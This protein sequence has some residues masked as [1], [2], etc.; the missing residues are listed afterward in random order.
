[1]TKY[2]TVTAI[3]KRAQDPLDS[4]LAF[5]LGIKKEFATPLRG[6]LDQLIY[7]FSRIHPGRCINHIE[8]MPSRPI[9][10]QEGYN[11]T[12]TTGYIA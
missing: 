8:E 7:L 12:H 4:L 9:Q 11:T 3:T 2:K 5:S 6:W 10:R 1:M